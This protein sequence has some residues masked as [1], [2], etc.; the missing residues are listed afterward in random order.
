LSGDEDGIEMRVGFFER[1][2]RKRKMERRY[3]KNGMEVKMK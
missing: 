3:E 1:K 2:K